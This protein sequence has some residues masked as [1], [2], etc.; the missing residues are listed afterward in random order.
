MADPGIQAL[1]A[2]REMLTGAAIP[3]RFD[4]TW[5]SLTRP[6]EP[7]V[8]LPVSKTALQPARRAPPA[9][10]N[11]AR[12]WEMVLPRMKRRAALTPSSGEAQDVQ[13][14]APSFGAPSFQS[15]AEGGSRSR[16]MLWAGVPLLI[17]IGMGLYWNGQRS[18]PGDETEAATMEMGGAGWISE[19]ASD[20]TGSARGRQI[21][22]YRPSMAMSDYRL[23]FVGQIE[24][25]SLGWVFRASDSSNYYVGKLEALRPGPSPLVITH[26]AVIGGMEGPHVQRV[27]AREPGAGLKVRLD[28]NGPQFTVYVQDQVVEEWQDD[29]LRTGGVGF[30]NER[31]ERARVG[32]IQ[33]SF[34]KGGIR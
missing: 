26:F 10:D 3:F 19:W 18:S 6:L 22:L 13:A 21:S 16:W 23:E 27:L 9:R 8:G 29:R 2:G 34:P 30:L 5:R 32:S 11:E 33:I 7:D 20:R 28:A 12:E 31:E 1:R 24:S 25:K 4:V 17:A 14:P 15:V